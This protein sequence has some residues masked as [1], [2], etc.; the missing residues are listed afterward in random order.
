VSFQQVQKYESGA[1]RISASKL[2][3]ATQ[4]LCMSPSALFEGLGS[5]D[6]GGDAII[7]WPEGRAALRIAQALPKLSTVLA[8]R[9]ADLIATVA[10]GAND[11]EDE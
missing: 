4:F 7:A 1:N 9:F 11:N 10:Q 5:P 2:F 3:A 8:N 6:I